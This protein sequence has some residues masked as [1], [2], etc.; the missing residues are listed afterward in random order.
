MNFLK[1]MI[2]TAM[3]LAL[4]LTLCFAAASAD[5][6]NQN[7]D[8]PNAVVAVSEPVSGAAAAA[9]GA[10]EPVVLPLAASLAPQQVVKHKVSF[11]NWDDEVVFSLELNDGEKIEVPALLNPMKVGHNFL[12]WADVTSILHEEYEFGKAVRGELNLKAEF[13]PIPVV[14]VEETEEETE[15]EEMV[16]LEMAA[17]EEEELED[18]E[19]ELEIIIIDEED[20]ES[21]G[22]FELEDDI[23]PL[24]GPS[25]LQSLPQRSVKITSNLGAS[26]N[27][28]DTITLRGELI[29]FDGC[30]VTLQWQFNN[31]A[32]WTN[33][34]GANDV[35]CSFPANSDTLNCDW[36]LAVSTAA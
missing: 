20:L 32:G 23:V 30:E 8:E 1:K 15:E 27:E 11:L 10:D 28:N 5:D 29:G 2:I 25:T 16:G 12:Y 18:D 19:D 31:G 3:M 24:A 4:A 7:T 36:R 14:T 17:V 9:P 26:V 22:M 35:T 33:L 34:E 6:E 13:E 21:A